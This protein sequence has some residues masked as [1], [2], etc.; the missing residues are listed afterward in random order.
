MYGH[1]DL[2]TNSADSVSK[3]IQKGKRPLTFTCARSGPVTHASTSR[4]SQFEFSFF[5]AEYSVLNMQ[6]Q[7]IF[8]HISQLIYIGSFS[9]QFQLLQ[10]TATF[11]Q[12]NMFWG[13]IFIQFEQT[14]KYCEDLV[15]MVVIVKTL[16]L[17]LYK[18][19]QLTIS[20][21]LLAMSAV[22]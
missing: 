18:D 1:G 16:F 14:Q 9:G 19:L 6:L 8:T 5:S 12:I 3:W 2:Q 20:I 4:E 15:I 22:L 21:S 17:L 13:E 10:S 11:K 7:I